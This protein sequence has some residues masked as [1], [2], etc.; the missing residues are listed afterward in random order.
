MTAPECVCVKSKGCS[1]STAC[2]LPCSS[3]LIQECQEVKADFSGSVGSVLDWG[4]KDSPPVTVL[5]P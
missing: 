2:E 3:G 4:S 1:T 5:C